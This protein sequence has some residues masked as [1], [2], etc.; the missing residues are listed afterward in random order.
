MWS[1][2]VAAR[3]AGRQAGARCLQRGHRPCL[4]RPQAGAKEKRGG[5]GRQATSNQ[6]SISQPAGLTV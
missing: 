4:A 3:R 6:V 2:D 1:G 5:M